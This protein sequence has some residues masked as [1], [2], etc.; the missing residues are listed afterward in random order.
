MQKKAAETTLDLTLKK[1]D[2]DHWYIEIL[3]KLH[4]QIYIKI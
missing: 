2:P 1:Q 4:I 3:T